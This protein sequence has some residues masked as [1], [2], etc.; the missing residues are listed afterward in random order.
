MSLPLMS[1][2][3]SIMHELCLR[4]QQK[5]TCIS[6]HANDNHSATT[7]CYLGGQLVL[8]FIFPEENWPPADAHLLVQFGI[9]NVRRRREEH[10]WQDWLKCPGMAPIAVHP[11]FFFRRIMEIHALPHQ[12]TDEAHRNLLALWSKQLNLSSNK[13]LLSLHKHFSIMIGKLFKL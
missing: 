12:V 9:K 8:A 2:P 1:L 5:L 3:V 4:L 13:V 11:R 6:D 10:I 7:L